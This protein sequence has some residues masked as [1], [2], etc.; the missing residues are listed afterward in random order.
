MPARVSVS[1]VSSAHACPYA[2]G[3]SSQPSQPT[4]PSSL[5]ALARVGGDCL[6]HGVPSRTREGNLFPLGGAL[7]QAGPPRDAMGAGMARRHASDPRPA[8]RESVRGACFR[9]QPVPGWYHRGAG[10]GSWSLS[11]GGVS[12][13][14][15]SRGNAE[16]G[17]GRSTCEKNGVRHI[18][19]LH[20]YSQS[21]LITVETEFD[22]SRSGAPSGSPALPSAR[23]R[24]FGLRPQPARR[25][26]RLATLRFDSP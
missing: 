14:E 23:L 7:G 9:A 12:G 11:M 22:S 1:A 3:M 26:W 19:L 5:D 21:E 10:R 16:W 17:D 18:A 2:S 25:H 4:V 13:H 15:G 6:A 8:E 24:G 20:P